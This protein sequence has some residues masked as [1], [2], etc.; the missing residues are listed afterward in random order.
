MS[1]PF[2]VVAVSFDVQELLNFMLSHL[3]VLA[4]ISWTIGVLLR[5]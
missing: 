1:F 5:K 3:L 4:L 2:I